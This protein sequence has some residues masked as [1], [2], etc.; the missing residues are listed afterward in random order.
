MEHL[1]R[2]VAAEMIVCRGEVAEKNSP[3]DRTYFSTG[4][5]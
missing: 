1:G 2:P 4:N 3:L 5:D